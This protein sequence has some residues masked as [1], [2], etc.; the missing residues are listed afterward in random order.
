MFHCAGGWQGHLTTVSHPCSEI[1]LWRR[2]TLEKLKAFHVPLRLS[3]RAH[4]ENDCL[5]IS[6]RNIPG[7]DVIRYRELNH[8]P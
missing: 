6:S 1:A 7:I 3:G 4:I 5:S 8:S 2:D